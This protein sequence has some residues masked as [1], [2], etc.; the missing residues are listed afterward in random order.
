MK[1][2]KRSSRPQKK[3]SKKMETLDTSRPLMFRDEPI[4]SLL[5][6]AEKISDLKNLGPAAEKGFHAAGIK[7]VSQFM[8]LGWK[9]VMKKLVQHNPRN[10]HSMYAYAVIGAEKN[11][12]W[13]Q[14]SDSDKREARE[15][16]ASLK[17]Q[18]KKSKS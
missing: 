7:S 9:K 14:I 18:K 1:R 16:M 12:F 8:K 5:K 10:R 13:N 15:F 2:S 17:P 4:E 11:I 3:P 6:R